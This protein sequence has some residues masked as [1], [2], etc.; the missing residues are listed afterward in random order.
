MERE[1]IE[2]T[3]SQWRKLMFE[4]YIETDKGKV[5]FEEVQDEHDEMSVYTE[6]RYKIFKRITDGKF[7]RINYKFSQEEGIMTED[8]DWD[9]DD[10][11]VISEVFIETEIRIVYK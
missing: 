9:I 2:L 11:Q 1:T 10:I 7:F 6:D 4:N 8:Y 5:W 3:N